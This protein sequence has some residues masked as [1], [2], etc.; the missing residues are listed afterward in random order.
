MI[1][2]LN[3]ITPVNAGILQCAISSLFLFN[4]YTNTILQDAFSDHKDFLIF[5]GNVLPRIFK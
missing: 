1:L 5:I 4:I 3:K 2:S